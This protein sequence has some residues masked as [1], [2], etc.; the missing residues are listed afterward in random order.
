MVAPRLSSWLFCDAHTLVQVH[1][2]RPWSMVDMVAALPEAV[3]R[4]AVVEA[5]GNKATS[6]SLFVDVVATLQRTR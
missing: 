1:V 6:Q 4:V 3:K 5:L 2:Y